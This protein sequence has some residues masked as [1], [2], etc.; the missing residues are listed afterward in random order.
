MKQTKTK[1]PKPPKA[2]QQFSARYPRLAQAWD[3]IHEAGKDGPLDEKTCRL[4]RLAAALGARQEGAV[5]SSVRKG[6]ALG[7]TAAEFEQVVALCAGS[8]G[9]PG[10]VAAFC[11]VHDVLD[12][13]KR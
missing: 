1:A 11:Q 7:I 6:L 8:L 12:A 3:L 4:V 5:H 13:P 10:A 2:F 9:M